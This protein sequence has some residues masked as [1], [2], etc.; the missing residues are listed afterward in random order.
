MAQNLVAK[1]QVA[2]L[3]HEPLVNRVVVPGVHD[4]LPHR[5]EVLLEVQGEAIHG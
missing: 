1:V 2:Q 5:G 3:L 4:G